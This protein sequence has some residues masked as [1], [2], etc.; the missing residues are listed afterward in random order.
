M[1]TGVGMANT[2][3]AATVLSNAAESV[4]NATGVTRYRI[5]TGIPELPVAQQAKGAA[6]IVSYTIEYDRAGTPG[7]VIYIL[8]TSSGE[9]AIANARDAMADAAELLGRDPIGREGQLTWDEAA[10]RQ[11]FTL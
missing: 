10:E 1:I 6:T 5:D 2:K 8:D 7:N 9:R 4:G 11:Y 3:H